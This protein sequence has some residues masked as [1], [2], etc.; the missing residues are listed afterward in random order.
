[1]MYLTTRICQNEAE[2]M[3]REIERI[4]KHM[5]TWSPNMPQSDW[6]DY[7]SADPQHDGRAKQ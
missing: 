7:A 1:M 4:K 2:M 6:S 3:L 5:E